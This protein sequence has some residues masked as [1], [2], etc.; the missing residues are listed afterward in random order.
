MGRYTLEIYV[1]HL[2]LFKALGAMI[3][4]E[5]FQ[6]FDWKLVPEGML[7]TVVSGVH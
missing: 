5:R 1:A 6:L 4:P 2:L 3:D 7:E